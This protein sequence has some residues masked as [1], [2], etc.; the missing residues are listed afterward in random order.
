M[1]KSTLERLMPSMIL[2]NA[3]N[4]AAEGPTE[5]VVRPPPV[6]GEG[7]GVAVGDLLTVFG[8]G[9]GFGATVRPRL[10]EEFVLAFCAKARITHAKSTEAATSNLFIT[11]SS[12]SWMVE[13]IY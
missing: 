5:G 1:Y 2:S 4:T 8:V 3:A 10:V 13:T 12:L 11:F 9:V 7:D 6:A